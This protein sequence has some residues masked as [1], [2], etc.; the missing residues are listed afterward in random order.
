MNKWYL[1]SSKED[2]YGGCRR[3]L[4]KCKKS[5]LKNVYHY[6]EVP[7]EDTEVLKK[8]F[9]VANDFADGEDELIEYLEEHFE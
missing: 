9:D 6:V 7:E 3:E 8:Y 5:N 2:D 1:V 4:V